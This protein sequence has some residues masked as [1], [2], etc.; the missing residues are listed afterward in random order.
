LLKKKRTMI[1]RDWAALYQQS[2]I[3][4]EGAYFEKTMLRF[5]HGGHPEELDIYASGDLAISKE[6]AACFTVLMVAG[7]DFDQKI[8]MLD[9]RRGQWGADE[10]V[11]QIIDIIRVWKPLR[12][13]IEKGQ[14]SM[15]IGPHLERRLR[16]EKISFAV[17]EMPPTHRGNKEARARPLQGRMSRGEVLFPSGA[18]WTDDHINELLRFPTGVYSDRVDADAWLAQILA[19]VQYRGKKRGRGADKNWRS[20][21]SGYTQKANSGRTSSMAS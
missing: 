11:E 9:E 5:Y 13:G 18:L 2:P 16:E 21:L 10:I 3:V 6:D 15:A 8:Y 12:F 19:D 7:L 20:K 1:P 4:E 14:I 17:E